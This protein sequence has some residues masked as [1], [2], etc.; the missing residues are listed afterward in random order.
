MTEQENKKYWSQNQSEASFKLSSNYL[1]FWNWPLVFM[2]LL[3][4]EDKDQVQEHP[5]SHA[6]LAPLSGEL[7]ELH[8][9][10][11]GESEKFVLSTRVL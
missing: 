2:F 6:G 5:R 3:G 1:I 4:S 8:F 9:Q 7:K 10:K 11:T